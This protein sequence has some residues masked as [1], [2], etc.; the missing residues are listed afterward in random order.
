MLRRFLLCT[1]LGLSAPALSFAQD[2]DSRLDQVLQRGQLKVCTTG[3]YKPYSYLRDDGQYEGIDI[4][5]AQSLA[6]SLGVRVKWISTTWK[7]LM[8]D[9][10]SQQCDI[11]V[12]GI[13]VSLERQKTAF[14]SQPLGIDGKIPLVRCQDLKR[15]ETLEQINQ[16]SVR[17]IEPPGGTNEVFARAHVPKAEL[18]LFADNV[19]IFDQL[20]SRQADVMITDASEARFQ[21]KHKPGL[22][23]VHPERYLQYSEKAFLLPRD[24]MAW[25]SYVDQWLHLSKATGAYDQV[26]NQWL[27]APAP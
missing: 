11:A 8:A 2:A 15:Y 9:F 17:L 26:V 23:A 7:S 21:Q 25:K 10:H 18:I 12:G 22:C 16:P 1:L 5:M 20:L 4:A 6:Q 3:D 19:K 27:A 14:F 24:D 13:S